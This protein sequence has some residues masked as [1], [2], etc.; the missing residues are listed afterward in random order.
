MSKKITGTISILIAAILSLVLGVLLIV[1]P[2]VTWY[3]IAIFI[4]VFLWVFFVY[5]V[6]RT[7]RYWKKTK[8]HIIG[9][10]ISLTFAVLLT[11]FW[12]AVAIGVVILIAIA[13][14]ALALI[15]IIYGVQL[16]ATK[17]KG[18]I[19]SFLKALIQIVFATVIL[20]L[21]GDNIYLVS[22]VIGI[23]YIVYGVADIIDF[24][25]EL[26]LTDIKGKRVKQRIHINPPILFTA[27]VPM[28]LL[29]TLDD[30]DEEEEVAKWTME[31]NALKEQSPDLEIFIHLGK[32]AAFGLGHCD[33][34]FEGKAYSYGTYDL[35]SN[36]F[37]GL[38]SDGV[39]MIADGEPYK[40]FSVKHEKKRLLGYKVVLNETQKE[41]IRKKLAEFLEDS[42]EWKPTKEGEMMDMVHDCNAKYFKIQHGPYKKYNALKTNCVGL[43]N[44]VCGQ[45]GGVDLMSNQGI[46]TPGTYCDFLDRQFRRKNSIIV[47]RNIYK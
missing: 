27:L 44:I 7:I 13:I 39:V 11:F 35:D 31:N 46:I 28:K 6:I 1:F 4:Y 18:G 32:N 20:I 37:F 29:R 45:G 43:A 12:D 42:V 21:P 25:R 10:V 40:E 8:I 30:P 5:E 34:I 24:F 3:L 23:Y 33:I 47:E 36:K 14:Y 9:A 15:N 22:L 38:F 19:M 41:A 17:S 2:D 26:L 16:F